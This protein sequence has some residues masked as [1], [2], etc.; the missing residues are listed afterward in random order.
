MKIYGFKN[1]YAQRDKSSSSSSN[2]NRIKRN[3]VV[4]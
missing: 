4:L 1:A 3:I 2:S